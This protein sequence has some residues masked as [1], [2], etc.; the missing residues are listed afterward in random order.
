ML[1][2][3]FLKATTADLV[4]T[5]N[6]IGMQGALESQYFREIPSMVVNKNFFKLI[7]SLRLMS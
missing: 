3:T 4:M 6:V 5:E 1:K 7:D 2:A